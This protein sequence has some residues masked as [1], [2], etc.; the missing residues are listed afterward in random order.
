[1]W[2]WNSYNRLDA[3]RLNH[4]TGTH[5]LFRFGTVLSAANLIH[6][7]ES[8][9]SLYLN[10]PFGCRWHHTSIPLLSRFVN[11]Q[12]VDSVLAMH[13][14]LKKNRDKCAQNQCSLQLG[15]IEVENGTCRFIAT[16]FI[17]S[18]SYHFAQTELKLLSSP[19]LV[20]RRGKELCTTY[21][22]LAG[23]THP[24]HRQSHFNIYDGHIRIDC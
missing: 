21:I 18:P 19:I 4:H 3:S 12:S 11:W 16:Y 14:F 22:Q 17:S 23:I 24:N 2:P 9:L 7:I 20:L 5:F 15:S 10:L 6:Y 13:N 1:M 8:T